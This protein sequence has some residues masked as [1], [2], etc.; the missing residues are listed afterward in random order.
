MAPFATIRY[1]GDVCSFCDR[2]K[3]LILLE[4]RYYSWIY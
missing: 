2:N 4:K 1:M 3:R